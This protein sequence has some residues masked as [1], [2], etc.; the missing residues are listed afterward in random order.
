MNR[1]ITDPEMLTAKNFAEALQNISMTEHQRRILQVHYSAPGRVITAGQ[2]ADALGYKSKD[3]ANAHYG[4]LASKLA[5]EIN[6]DRGEDIALSLLNKFDISKYPYKWIMRLQV[7]KALSDLKWFDRHAAV[8]PL[9]EDK[10]IPKRIESTIDRIIRDTAAARHLKERYEYHCQVCGLQIEVSL[11]RYYAEVHHLRP[12]GGEHQGGDSHSNMLVLCPN[13]HAMFDLLIPRFIDAK[14]IVIENQEF[15]LE[16]RHRLSPEEID[17]HNSLQAR[18][19][20]AWNNK[21]KQS[22]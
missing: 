22:K 5:K 4:R 2:M 9:I 7:A 17:Y 10:D 11:G 21:G 1:T 18:F 6:F 15:Q 12:L 16:L 20:R 13:H 8:P 19:Q 3:P 14:R